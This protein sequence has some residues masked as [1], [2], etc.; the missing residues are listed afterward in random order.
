MTPDL[1][2][3]GTS[4]DTHIGEVLRHLP[5]DLSVVRLDVDRYPSQ[6]YLDVSI[7]GIT[8]K[9][10]M[11]EDDISEPAVCWFRRLGQPG[12][13]PG[14]SAGVA[15][16]VRG[17]TE[18]ALTSMLSIIRPRSWVNEYWACRR[19]SSKL[20]QLVEAAAVGLSTPPTLVSNR[21][22]A[23]REWMN[24][25]DLII[26]KTLH[27]P[28]IDYGEHSTIVFTTPVQ[29]L[30]DEIVA[31]IPVAPCQFQPNVIKAFELRVTSI[32]GRNVAVKI[33]SQTT[34]QGAQDWRAGALEARYSMFEL[35]SEVDSQ[36][37]RLLDA[38]GLSFGA[39]DFIVTPDGEYFFLEVNPHG[40]WVWMERELGDAPISRAV[41][42]SIAER[43]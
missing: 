20:L 11:D 15:K 9:T 29:A 10:M 3:V 39:T 14:L 36:L 38:L 28:I 43:I 13:D 31:S 41:A 5:E 30:T 16:W 23:V 37:T 2:V 4:I 32:F 34:Q 25:Y 27:A 40:A 22:E 42:Q 26:Y 35:P 12:V 33:D 19:A 21:V 1:L 17:E 18:Q 6:Q 24:R 8:S 7:D